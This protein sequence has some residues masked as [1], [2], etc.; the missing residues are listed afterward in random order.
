MASEPPSNSGEET[1]DFLAARRTALAMGGLAAL[2]WLL[3][4]PDN[5]LVALM[6]TLCTA[7]VGLAAIPLALRI[8]GRWYHVPRSERLLHMLLG[9]PAFGWM[10][11]RSGWNRIVALPMRNKK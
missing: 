1:V 5:P 2:L 6:V 9:V 3:L 10:L 4:G 11:E 8:P 7:N